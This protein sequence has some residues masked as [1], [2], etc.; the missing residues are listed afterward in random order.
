MVS[1]GDTIH[2]SGKVSTTDENCLNVQHVLEKVNE[3]KDNKCEVVL[4]ANDIY[5]DLRV[6]GYDYGHRFQKLK[7]FKTNDFNEVYGEIEW[8]GNWVTFV[9]SLLQTMVICQPFRKLLVPVMLKY[10]RCDPKILNRVIESNRAQ[11]NQTKLD[12]SSENS[13]NER[14]KNNYKLFVSILPY[15]LDMETRI[16]VSP[17]LEIE[18]IIVEPIPTK[19]SL[20]DIRLETYEFIA[21][22]DMNAIEE[23]QRQNVLRYI[24]VSF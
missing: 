8:D 13:L 24:K 3:W 18:N 11:D 5:K 19:N 2:C 17:G 22:E 6:R 20:Q 12:G 10:L 1:Q 16:V 21:N 9:D 7:T 14:I 4:N 15:R 23:N